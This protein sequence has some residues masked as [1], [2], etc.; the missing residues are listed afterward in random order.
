LRLLIDDTEYDVNAALDNSTLGDL[1]TLKVSTIGLLGDGSQGVTVPWAREKFNQGMA[2]MAAA[3]TLEK[4]EE[5]LQ[6]DTEFLLAVAAIIWLAKRRNGE[7]LTVADALARGFDDFRFKF[8]PE[9]FA[10]AA[11]PKAP[12]SVPAESTGT[13]SPT[14][15]STT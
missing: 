4:G 5:A 10:P 13:A 11:D 15:A 1:I 3:K 2:S 7:H 6:S 14:P 9:D 8:D 12:S